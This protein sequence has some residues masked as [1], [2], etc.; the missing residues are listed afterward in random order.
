MRALKDMMLR[1]L[2]AELRLKLDLGENLVILTT[3]RELMNAGRMPG[4]LTVDQVEFA[5]SPTK[6]L[7]LDPRRYVEKIRVQVWGVEELRLLNIEVW[8]SPFYMAWAS[9]ASGGRT[10]TAGH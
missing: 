3:P 1:D 4:F 9:L 6:G 5:Y 7:P 2:P 10:T 8:L